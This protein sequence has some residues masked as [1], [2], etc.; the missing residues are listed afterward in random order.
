MIWML[1]VRLT[2]VF[3]SIVMCVQSKGEE[4]DVKDKAVEGGC[5]EFESNK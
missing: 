5:M 3:S 2:G 1:R 4:E